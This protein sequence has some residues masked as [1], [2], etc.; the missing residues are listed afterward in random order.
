VARDATAAAA[1]RPL[2]G[3]RSSAY[4]LGTT[5]KLHLHTE[6]HDE[7][8]RQ[9]V[10]GQALAGTGGHSEEFQSYVT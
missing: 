10:V 4:A 1:L 6:N 2:Y 9:V 3:E 5:T 7:R 8:P